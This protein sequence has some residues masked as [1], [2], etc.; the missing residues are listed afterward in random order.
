MRSSVLLF[1][2]S[3]VALDGTV[4]LPV[5]FDVSAI[6]RNRVLKSIAGR[7]L[8]VFKIPDAAAPAT[9]ATDVVLSTLLIKNCVASV[10]GFDQSPL[11]SAAVATKLTSVRLPINVQNVGRDV[12]VSKNEILVTVPTHQII[13]DYAKELVPSFALVSVECELTFEFE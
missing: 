2:E 9:T 13:N 4:T 10:S 3:P 12:L 8:I 5:I 1:E 6:P 11:P 7:V